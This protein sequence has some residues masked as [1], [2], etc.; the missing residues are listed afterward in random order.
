M[1]HLDTAF[2]S[3]V[4]EVRSASPSYVKIKRCAEE[5]RKAV[6]SFEAEH[7]NKGTVRKN[8]ENIRRNVQIIVDIANP[9]SLPELL[10]VANS[11]FI[12]INNSLKAIAVELAYEYQEMTT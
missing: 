8:L 1:E 3:L 5:L 7:K 11:S 4:L 6:I 10:R 9:M 12:S 2:K